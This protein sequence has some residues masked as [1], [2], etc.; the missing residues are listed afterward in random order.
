MLLPPKEL[1]GVFENDW[2]LTENGRKEQ[3]SGGQKIS[4]NVVYTSLKNI[5]WQRREKS[6]ESSQVRGARKEYF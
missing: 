5:K 1:H 6:E 3:V 2:S 4:N